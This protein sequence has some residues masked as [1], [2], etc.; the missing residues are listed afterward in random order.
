VCSKK[1]C[2]LNLSLSRFVKSLQA[3]YNELA[4]TC[5]VVGRR[6]NLAES[7]AEI[8]QE[9]AQTLGEGCPTS[10]ILD[11]MEHRC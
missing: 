4:R 9:I 7:S 2:N 11:F 10:F 5:V 1:G 3:A 8:K 6:P